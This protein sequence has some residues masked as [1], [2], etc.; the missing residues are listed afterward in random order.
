[1]LTR[2][3]DATGRPYTRPLVSTL[4]SNF[5]G[6]GNTISNL[7]VADST[8]G[9][10][11]LFGDGG[12]TVR[13]LILR[14]VDIAATGPSPHAGAL[15]GDGRATLI[16]CFVTG[17]VS[18]GANAKAGGLIGAGNQALILESDAAVG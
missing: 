17:H 10:V 7:S 12:G 1:A 4:R 2:S 5:E 6:L 3:L 13:N 18:A 16:H 8:D 9:N 14:D 15:I 11:G